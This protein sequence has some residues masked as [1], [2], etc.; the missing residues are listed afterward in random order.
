MSRIGYK[1]SV[2]NATRRHSARMTSAVKYCAITAEDVEGL[3]VATIGRR[4][5]LLVAI[6]KL[7]DGGLKFEQKV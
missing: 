5:R 4:R 6:G 3:G 7:R 1:R 2:W